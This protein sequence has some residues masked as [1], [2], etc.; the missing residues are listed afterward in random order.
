MYQLKECETARELIDYLSPLNRER[1]PREQYVFRGQPCASYSLAPAAYRSKGLFTATAMFEHAGGVDGNGQIFF[2]VEMLKTFLEACDGSG[3]QVT[4]DSTDLRQLLV[5]PDYYYKRPMEWP[6]AEL[7]P[8]LAT[9]QHH[10]APTCLLDWTRRSYVAAYFAA[11]GALREQ[12]DSSHLAVWAL[13]IFRRLDWEDLSFVEM[14]GGTSANLA[15]QAGV[16]TVSGIKATKGQHFESTA[17][18]HQPDVYRFESNDARPGLVKITLPASEAAN[19][20][21]YCAD[22]GVKGSVLFPGYEG[23]AREVNDYAHAY[24]ARHQR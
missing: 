7:F 19:L 21:E 24:L 6:P 9:A 8:V 10:G 3:I 14:P 22:F 18:E 2:E 12:N 5:S 1:W 4:G 17:I 16:F 13:C 23:A 15:A 11:A 20:L